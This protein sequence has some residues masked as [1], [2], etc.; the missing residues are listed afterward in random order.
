MMSEGV[1]L[2]GQ[3]SACLGEGE[4]FTHSLSLVGD[5]RAVQQCGAIFLRDNQLAYMY[6]MW[7]VASLHTSPQRAAFM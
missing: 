3:W 4:A 6:Y 5:R 1:G 7:I 2:S